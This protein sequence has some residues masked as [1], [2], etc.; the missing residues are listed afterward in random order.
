[1]SISIPT[2]AGEF[3]VKPKELQLSSK[4]EEW[5]SSDYEEKLDMFMT[6]P[7]V[8]AFICV[9]NNFVTV[10][11]GVSVTRD[12]DSKQAKICSG[13]SGTPIN[14][15]VFADPASNIYN[16]FVTWEFPGK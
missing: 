3:R 13:V 7:D 10:V 5:A 4:V 12:P 14:F 8:T 15:S 2:T 11:E 6:D 16:D 1:M 9:H